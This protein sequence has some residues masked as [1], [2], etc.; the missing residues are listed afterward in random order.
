M[1]PCFFGRWRRRAQTHA[2]SEAPAS[3]AIMMRFATNSARS[4][5]YYAGP[6]ELSTTAA[7][8][9]FVLED[10]GRARVPGIVRELRDA[11]KPGLVVPQ[12]ADSAPLPMSSSRIWSRA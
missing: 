4:R 8:Q 3:N 6:S 2:I 5:T 1:S 9:V 11:A 10:N 7:S 12:F